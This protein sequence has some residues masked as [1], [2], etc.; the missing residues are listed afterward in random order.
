MRATSKQT[1]ETVCPI[2][3]K[4]PHGCNDLLNTVK[5]GEACG[6]TSMVPSF[7]DSVAIGRYQEEFVDGALGANNPGMGIM[8]PSSGRMGTGTA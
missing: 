7:F 4:S 3:Y 8:E 2:S 1:S 5:V 6:V